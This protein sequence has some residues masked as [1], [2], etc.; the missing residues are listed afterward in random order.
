MKHL[1][2]YKQAPKSPFL[3]LLSTTMVVLKSLRFFKLSLLCLKSSRWKTNLS[4]VF[5]EAH[6]IEGQSCA[7]RT[8][9]P[10]KV[11]AQWKPKEMSITTRNGDD[12]MEN[13][14]KWMASSSSTLSQ[15]CWFACLQPW[16]AHGGW[17]SEKPRKA[18]L[19]L[20]VWSIWEMLM[21]SS[22]CYPCQSSQTPL[23]TGL[24]NFGGKHESWL[25]CN[26]K[27]FVT[28]TR[29][30]ASKLFSCNASVY[31]VPA[32]AGMAPE[33]PQP[34]AT[35]TWGWTAVFMDRGGSLGWV[36]GQGLL[37]RGPKSS[38]GTIFKGSP[39]RI[40]S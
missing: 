34:W 40:G 27:C 14:P 1:C 20:L 13:D 7:N 15:H 24:S 31:N 9:E 26:V 25:R 3:S 32:L 36:R 21:A 33:K 39:A 6:A 2:A 19:S 8:Q 18:Q 38:T 30:I 35:S 17:H 23:G 5:P 29:D 10:K 16:R 37:N 28:R 4:G 12:N 11:I 22:I